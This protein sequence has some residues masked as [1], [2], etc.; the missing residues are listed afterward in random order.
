M[1]TRTWVLIA[2]AVI[3]GGSYAYFFTHWF[4]H[5]E[6]RINYQIRADPPPRPGRRF[7]PSPE[8]RAGVYPVV[9][10]LDKDYGVTAIKVF[11]SSDLAANKDAAPIWSLVASD[12]AKPAKV[13]GFRYG[14]PPRGMK[15]AAPEFK[16][17][18]ALTPGITYLLRVETPGLTGETE[19]RTKELPAGP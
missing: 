8:A 14:H 3:L 1:G 18:P 2:I 17:A 10:N 15:P 6:L 19:F 5:E 7:R 9:F 11:M 4:E 12:P 16:T 13:Q